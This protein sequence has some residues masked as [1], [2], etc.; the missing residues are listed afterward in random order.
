MPQQPHTPH[1]QLAPHPGQHLLFFWTVKI[2]KWHYNYV[3]VYEFKK[4]ILNACIE[5]T[6]H[7]W[8]REPCSAGCSM[9][10]FDTDRLFIHASNSFPPSVRPSVSAWAVHTTDSSVEGRAP[11]VYWISQLSL[12][13]FQLQ[14]N[15]SWHSFQKHSPRKFIL[16]HVS[17]YVSQKING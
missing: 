13:K 15:F 1:H 16:L 6:A 7:L 17:V 5:N 3:A 8:S 10:S 2:R 9:N 14:F 12:W 4:C 11:S